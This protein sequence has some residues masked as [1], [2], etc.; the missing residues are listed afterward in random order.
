MKEAQDTLKQEKFTTEKLRTRKALIKHE[1]EQ[2]DAELD[3]TKRKLMVRDDH[4][5]PRLEK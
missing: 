1:M 5:M 3:Q 2:L 4:T